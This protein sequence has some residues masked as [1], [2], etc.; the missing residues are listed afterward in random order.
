[1]NLQKE[2]VYIDY[3]ENGEKLK[4]A[5]HI[6]IWL[7]DRS[8][9]LD[10]HMKGLYNTD[11]M[12]AEMKGIGRDAVIGR[13]CI[14]KG[15]A[16]FN[17]SFP[18]DDMDG[19]GTGFYDLEGVCIRLSETRTLEARWKRSIPKET[20][21]P[22][23]TL[24]AA[25]ETVKKEKRD[26]NILQYRDLTET[27]REETKEP[28][29]EEPPVLEPYTEPAEEETVNGTDSIKGQEQA[30]ILYPDKWTQLRHT[31]QV[32]HPF[33]TQEYIKISPK[34]FTILRQEYQQLV[35][36]S[37]LLHGY[38]NYRHLILGKEIIRGKEVFYL[39]VPGTYY[40]REKMVAI[41]FGFESF[42]VSEQEFSQGFI[43][44]GTFG[45]YLRTVEL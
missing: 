8:C 27:V 10:V 36:N 42:E 22:Q 2:I 26:N 40:E 25:S 34:D 3:V 45:Y 41:M 9:I 33:T 37:F 7:R 11:T 23:A 17:G 12:M 30:D 20:D 35:N 29:W 15:S 28:D 13:I 14:D 6:K 39:G 38:Y 44:E 18:I 1:M 4:N 32:V 16:Y 31:Y 5:G 24:N 19:E 21:R 43:P